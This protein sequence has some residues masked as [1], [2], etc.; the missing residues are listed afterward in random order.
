MIKLPIA[1]SL[2]IAYHILYKIR[3]F[4]YNISRSAQNIFTY[5][6]KTTYFFVCS[7]SL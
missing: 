5:G 1:D 7:N 3:Q 4:L 6:S 2:Y